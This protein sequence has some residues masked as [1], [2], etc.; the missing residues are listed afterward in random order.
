MTDAFLPA[1]F[2][3]DWLNL[4]L[5]W[6]H[7]I[8]GIAWIGTSFF[9][10]WLDLALSRREGQ[11]PGI[12]GSA[13]LVHGGGFYDVAKY[14]VAPAS[15]PPELHWFKWEAYLTWATGL[16]LLV[17]LYYAQAS[18]YLIDPA[19]AALSPAQAS[20][21]GLLSLLAG[22]FVYD[23][24]VRWLGDRP[25]LLAAALF[26]VIVAAA[27]G[28]SSLFSGRG[29]LIHVGALVGTWMA[30]N[31]FAVIIPNQKKIIASLL[32]HDA[33]DPA[34]GKAGKV[35]SVH[36]TYLTLPVLLLMVSN[37]YSFLTGHRQLW[38]VVALIVL[39]GAAVR[40]LLSRFEAGEKLRRYAWAAPVA[41]AGLAGLVVATAPTAQPVASRPAD[42]TVLAIAQTHCAACHA[43]RPSFPGFT[44]PPKE[45]RLQT[46]AQLRANAARVHA[47]AVASQVMPPGN[48][49]GITAAERAA[50][51]AW[52]AE[53][54]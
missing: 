20:A 26:A 35:R 43:D 16:G 10:I 9:F 42:A 14:T 19:R 30:A 24:L 40:H 33:P 5:R 54:R 45:L 4:L 47:Q 11:A 6:A 52:L 34:L 53:A 51:G 27:W 31:V 17:V 49:T 39:T 28:Y 44:E 3:I 29:A 41:L 1:H 32:R 12:L 36:N 2:L 50:L 23:L 48:V 38:L 37:H 22:W 13:W 25:G 15:L 21:I 46:L 7:L 18:L 8:V